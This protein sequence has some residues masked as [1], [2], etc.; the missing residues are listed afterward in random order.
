[1]IFVEPTEVSRC[2]K[3]F[4][5]CNAVLKAIAT[6]KDKDLGKALQYI[7]GP[8]G[9][10]RKIRLDITLDALKNMDDKSK[11][12]LYIALHARFPNDPWLEAHLPALPKKDDG[13]VENAPDN[14]PEDVSI[15]KWYK[16]GTVAE[17]RMCSFRPPKLPLLGRAICKLPKLT[18]EWVQWRGTCPACNY[19]A[20]KLGVV[21]DSEP[22]ENGDGKS[23]NSTSKDSSKVEN[24][25]SKVID[26]NTSDFDFG[27]DKDSDGGPSPRTPIE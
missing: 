2:Q 5:G 9:L 4:V 12:E 27:I 7:W 16:P 24:D 1:V 6:D 19:R 8:D 15:T 23:E 18:T 26:G 21:V 20:L 17:C 14:V 13:M 25:H 11:E 22:V 10:P 3:W